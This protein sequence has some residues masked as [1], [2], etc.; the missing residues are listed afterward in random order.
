MKEFIDIQTGNMRNE[1]LFKRRILG[2]T[3]YFRSAQENLLPSYEMSD[4]GK[5]Y[6]LV[7]CEMSD[8][9]IGVY[10]KVRKAEAE[11]EKNKRKNEAKNVGENAEDILTIPSTY[12]IFSR[13]CCNFAFPG[14]DL[15]RPRPDKI[16]NGE[17]KDK[18]ENEDDDVDMVG[19]QLQNNG[20]IDDDRE[21]NDDEDH[22]ENNAEGVARRRIERGENSVTSIH[23]HTS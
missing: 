8:F 5:I 15:E 9:Q 11:S 17:K 20:E 18:N 1:N 3:S 6:H 22:N 14:G 23:L 12:R 19:L 13:A 21:E 16:E 2:M 7:L 4:S 10:D